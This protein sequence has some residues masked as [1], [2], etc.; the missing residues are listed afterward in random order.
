MR[1]TIPHAKL[2]MFREKSGSFRPVV[3][4]K[5]GAVRFAGVKP[6]KE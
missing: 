4:M 3:S 6:E 5:I 1:L 2:G